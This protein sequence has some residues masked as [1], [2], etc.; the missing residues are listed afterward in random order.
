MSITLST[1]IGSVTIKEAFEGYE[2]GVDVQR[3][4]FIMKTYLAPTWASAFPVVNALMG[5]G[6]TPTRHVCPESPNLKCLS[7]VLQPRGEYDIR[8]SGRPQFNL[9]VIKA[10]YGI[11]TWDELATDNAE[12][13]FPNEVNPGQSYTYMEQSI[14]FDTEVIKV[15]GRAY[16]FASDS[17]PIDTPIAVNVAVATFVLVRRWQEQ[18]PYANVTRYLNNL[19]TATFLGQPRGQIKFRKAKTRRQFTSD[20]TVAQEVE[21]T[22]LW[23][24]YDHNKFHRPD[25]SAFEL[26]EDGSG[27]NPY[28]YADLTQLLR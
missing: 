22:F 8:D 19:N 9:A 23:R 13:S 27:N 3:G 18:L 5:A 4:P 15:P 21:Y 11:P 17:K 14:D 7:A 6:R 20:G 16:A 2:A 12:N 25:S 1:S 10:T 26:I 24:Q 28:Q